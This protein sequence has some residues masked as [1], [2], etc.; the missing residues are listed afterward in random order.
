MLLLLALV[1][2]P[3]CIAIGYALSDR[4][5]AD[6][7]HFIG[8]GNFVNLFDDQ[9]YRQTAAQHVALHGRIGDAEAGVRR[10]GSR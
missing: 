3:F 2:Y 8:L 6:D 1:A 10:S 9:I 7:G 5:L 4:T